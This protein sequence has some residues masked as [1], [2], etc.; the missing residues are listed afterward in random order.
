MSLFTVLI[1]VAAPAPPC[2]FA[3]SCCKRRWERGYGEHATGEV[4]IDQDYSH[5]GL[6]AVEGCEGC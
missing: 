3:L 4:L 1:L 6:S 2:M 5:F